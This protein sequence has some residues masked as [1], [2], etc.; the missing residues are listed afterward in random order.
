MFPC[1]HPKVCM[2]ILGE[3][4]FQQCQFSYLMPPLPHPPY[5]STPKPLLSPARR[6]RMPCNPSLAGWCSPRLQQVAML[7][8]SS[9]KSTPASPG[10]QKVGAQACQ[11]PMMPRFTRQTCNPTSTSAFS[12]VS[13]HSPLFTCSHV[14]YL[15][16]S[17]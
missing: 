9:A 7:K 5:I 17:F 16:H 12:H 8:V 2:S 3:G 13:T 4:W 14:P 6:R 1:T 11:A 15:T 10:T